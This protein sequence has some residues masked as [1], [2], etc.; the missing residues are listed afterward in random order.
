MRILQITDTHLFGN[1]EQ[2]LLGMNTSVSFERIISDIANDSLSADLIVATGDI[3]QDASEQAYLHFDAA[4]RKLSCPY[5]WI[6]G[7]HDDREVMTSLALADNPFIGDAALG[8][9][10]LIMLDTSV[11]GSVHGLLPESELQRLAQ[12]LESVERNKSLQHSLIFLH[13][14]PIQGNAGWMSDIGL[15]NADEF[16]ELLAR[17]SSVRA[18]VYGH[19][20]QELDAVYDGIRYICTPST[21]IQ[22]KPGVEDFALDRKTPAYRWL[23]LQDNGEINTWVHRL[24]NFK[25]QIDERAAGY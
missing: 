8:N 18:V 1:S 16:R 9:W 12:L 3:A 5:Y 22:F 15:H 24:E 13:H 25:I 21:C 6:P 10:L 23:E 4:V 17:Y 20:H 14:N 11:R 2:A 19:I 7:N